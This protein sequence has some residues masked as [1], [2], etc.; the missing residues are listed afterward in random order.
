M[1]LA[2]ADV[3]CHAALSRSIYSIEGCDH[4]RVTAT[5]M[6]LDF[7]SAPT[8][9]LEKALR[10]GLTKSKADAEERPIAGRVRG[11]YPMHKLSRAKSASSP[12]A[13]RRGHSVPA[14]V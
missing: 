3:S 7:L 10:A 8:R 5:M 2:Q 13:W 6:T 11:G 4:F 14:L 9:R 12:R 1:L